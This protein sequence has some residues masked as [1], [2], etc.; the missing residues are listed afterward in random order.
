MA[1][2]T[3]N[4]ENPKR[5]NEKDV[6]EEDVEEEAELGC[7]LCQDRIERECLAH[8]S[9]IIIHFFGVNNLLTTCVSQHYSSS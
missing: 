8:S 7:R 6:A 3:A 1:C 9:H 2:L 4:G 5:R